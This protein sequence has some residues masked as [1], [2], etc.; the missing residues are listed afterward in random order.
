MSRKVWFSSVMSNDQIG[1]KLGLR[2]K[3]HGEDWRPAQHEVSPLSDKVFAAMQRHTQGY[4]LERSDFPEASAVFDKKRFARVGDL[5]VV[6]AFFAVKERLAEVL[7]RFNLG[8]GGL[9]PFPIYQEDLKTP[10][11]GKFY[12]L[13]FGARKRTVRQRARSSAALRRHMQK[14]SLKR[15]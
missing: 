13:N 11:E 12:C 14:R 8:D 6:G 15:I 9:V 2:T 5:F 3:F 4:A 7:A 10:V 1:Y